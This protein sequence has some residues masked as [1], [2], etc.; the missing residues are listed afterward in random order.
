QPALPLVRPVDV[1]RS[2]GAEPHPRVRARL[3]QPEHL[4]GVPNHDLYRNELE[5]TSRH[6]GLRGTIAEQGAKITP[7]TTGKMAAMGF[8]DAGSFDNDDAAEFAGALDGATM[9]ARTEL[10][11]SALERVANT[12]SR[13]DRGRLIAGQAP[14]ELARR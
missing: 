3:A 5:L 9:E 14:P 10:V 1:P 8:W 6:A 13:L 7:A 2:H 4:R 11:G 12:T